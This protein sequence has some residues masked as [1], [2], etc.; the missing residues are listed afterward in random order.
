[1]F[2]CKNTTE[3]N[4]HCKSKEEMKE[5]LNYKTLK[6]YF[7]D[8][9]LTPVNYDN[10]IKERINFLDA[11]I[12]FNVGEYLYNEM[13]LVRIETSNNIIGFDFLSNPKVNEFIK[14]DNVEI[15][16]QPGYNLDDE[17]MII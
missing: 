10:P 8:I 13:Q 4:H 1:M 2:P 7:E 3:N 17:S 14:F 5:F 11:G 12:F 6:L 9:L 15:I 16:P